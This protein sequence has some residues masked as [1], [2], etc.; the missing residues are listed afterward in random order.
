M[1]LT[2][3][4]TLWVIYAP[5]YRKLY[6]TQCR[7][8][9]RVKFIFCF[10]RWSFLLLRPTGQMVERC[11]E[12]SGYKTNCVLQLDKFT[13]L[14]LHT[15]T[16]P[17]LVPLHD[18]RQ[19]QTVHLQNVHYIAF[20]TAWLSGQKVYNIMYYGRYD[21]EQTCL[22]QRRAGWEQLIE[23]IM[24]ALEHSICNKRTGRRSCWRL[25][26]RSLA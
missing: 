24:R 4:D 17:Q 22:R 7:R 23:D 16:P 25:T 14:T 20:R 5:I 3:G 11:E 15:V 10:F 6:C 8:M 26:E 1:V 2:Q 19:D 12:G 21:Y 9:S 18:T 13:D